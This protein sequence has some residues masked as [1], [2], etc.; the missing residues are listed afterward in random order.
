MTTV[1]PHP[2]D[3]PGHRPTPNEPDTELPPLHAYPEADTPNG[4]HIAPH[5]PAGSN[6]HRT[7]GPGRNGA[8]NAAHGPAPHDLG[9]ER[10]LLGAMLLSP[11]AADIGADLLA[12]RDFYSP[13][14]GHVF[15]A[16]TAARRD[17]EPVDPVTIADR[18]RR[19]GLLDTIG[20]PGLLVA[21]IAD[22]PATSNAD[23]YAA[24]IAAHAHRRA[25]L[26]V[27]A[28]TITAAERLDDPA[29]IAARVTTAV[30]AI[31]GRD[32]TRPLPWEDVA[33]VMRGDVDPVTPEILHR[34]D[35]QALIY[36]GLTHWLMGEPGKGKA[37]PLDARILTPHGWTTMGAL[38][39]GDHVIGSDGHPT[40]VTGIYPQGVIDIYQVTTSD[41]A[42][43]EACGD[44]LWL[45]YSHNDRVK[46]RAGTVRTTRDIAHMLATR[47]NAR[48]LHLPVVAPVHHTPTG[49]LPVDP[50][51][52][53]LLI[54][55]GGLTKGVTYTTTDPE[56]LD[57]VTALVPPDVTPKATSDPQ[58]WALTTPR[59]A[60]NPLLDALRSLGLIGGRSETKRVPAA[61]LVASIPDRVALLQGLM[62]SDGTASGRVTQ[63]A[64]SSPGL[65]DD[66]TDL[67]RGLGGVARRRTRTPRYTHRG[68]HRTGLT[69]HII[70]MRLPAGIEPFR[71][72]RKLEQWRHDRAGGNRVPERSIVAVTPAGQKPAQCI[73]VA[74]PDHLY[75]TDGHI[76]THNTWV[77]LVAAAEQIRAGRAVMYLDYEGSARI[78]GDRMRVLGV[79]PD[80]VDACLLYLRP[81]HITGDL[82]ARL[83]ASVAATDAALVVIDGVAKALAS[84]GLS[85]DSAPDVLS[86][87]VTAV[88]P[89]AD[90]GAAVL[91]LDHVV[92]EKE[93]RGLWARG[94][95]AKL[96]EVSGA[97][98]VLR[99]DQ[100]FSRTQTGRARLVQ[101]KDREGHVGTDG[102][103][104]ATVQFRPDPA[105]G[106]LD[107]TL[108]PPAT[109]SG[110]V[111]RPTALMEQVSRHVETLNAAGLTPGANEI[112][113]AVHGKRTYVIEAL[114]TLIAE[115]HITATPGA[116]GARHHTVARPYRQIDDPQSDRH[117]PP[118]TDPP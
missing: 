98:W 31:D 45:T 73:S 41:G 65:A 37:Q 15:A 11:D 90:A 109:E 70:N 54:G 30:A 68:E 9:A 94:S 58:T 33:A 57:A 84:A 59:G 87:L 91:M 85:E 117:E 24:V 72:A 20:G 89:L 4:A 17:H 77:A 107:I 60:P 96:G 52:L 69:S 7:P 3:D 53:G 26:T 93:G 95:G 8:R 67:V 103:V 115:G 55:D 48:A 61:Y 78:V 36:P 81:G 82:A 97:A 13:A 47:P 71:L 34:T 105:R 44:H 12:A 18:L 64:T 51:L 99:P 21:L 86:W 56:L 42:T 38:T 113:R 101:A 43:V 40:A 50:Y 106:T 1:D 16:I 118:P 5:G 6:G 10:S 88:N 76:V 112:T 104:V 49:P 32:H 111:V 114:T 28:D 19:A 79:G 62:D 29:D 83:T 110:H 22:T 75:V 39:V 102:A 23:R 2:V 63:F 14:H 116:R 80:Q 66:V 100:P 74:A 27:A 108:D 25:L 35:G 92:K 46:G